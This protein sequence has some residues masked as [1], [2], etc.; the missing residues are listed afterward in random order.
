MSLDPADGSPSPDSKP[1]RRPRYSGT[2]PRTFDQK[3]KELHPEKYPETVQKVIA[4]G[5]TPAGSHRPIM[6]RETLEALRPQAGGFFVDCTLGHGGH[7]MAILERIRPG[8]RLLGL[9]VDPIEQPRT[10]AR[11]RDLG[12]GPE[13]LA[14]AR[15]NFAG[16]LGVIQQRDWGLADGVMADLGV[17]SMQLD[18]PTRGFSA[19]AEG[20][21][22][23]RMN[24]G[25]GR[26]G[27]ELLTSLPAEK[28]ALLLREN[29]D[30]PHAD[31]LASE[32]K[33]RAIRTTSELADAVRKALAFL[34]P[35]RAEEIETSVKRVFQAV[36][37]AVN[38][39]FGALEN[40]LRVLPSTLKPGGRAVI[41]TFHSGEDRRV[42][43]AFERDA[44]AG[45]YSSVS[46]EPLRP[47]SEEVAANSRARSA[48]LRWAERAGGQM[49]V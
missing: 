48:K 13:E 30:E 24:P 12:C 4:S 16:V 21:L 23:L 6:V 43:A 20:P 39:E 18:N 33:R 40:L 3:Y 19:K 34:A 29:S 26:S 47:S 37:I 35:A 8:G 41:L 38:D 49:S 22:D 31:L 17:S 44:R 25:R 5:K 32:L 36:R 11:L 10:E 42:K 15:S 27:A 9:D 45:I 2:H 7:A 14:V 1:K 46:R 28:L